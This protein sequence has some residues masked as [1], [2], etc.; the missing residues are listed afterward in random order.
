MLTS[1]TALQIIG[2]WFIL[3]LLFCLL[4]C[5]AGAKWAAWCDQAHFRTMKKKADLIAEIDARNCAT[6]D[7]RG[8]IRTFFR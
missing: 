5:W 1:Y 3:S 7:D 8:Q 6:P 4:I 2:V